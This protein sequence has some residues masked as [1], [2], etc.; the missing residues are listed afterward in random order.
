MTL[1]R[2]I[3]A[4][5][6]CLLAVSAQAQVSD[7]NDLRTLRVGMPAATLPADGFTDL[8]CSGGGKSLSNWQQ[9]KECRPDSTGLRVISFRYDDKP[10]HETVVAGQPV[11]LSLGI[12]DDGF[13]HAIT[14]R[15]DPSGRVFLRKRGVHFGERVMNHYGDDGW[16]CKDGE[17]AAGEEAVG[18][19]FIR[20]HCEKTFRDRSLVVDRALYRRTG[21][22]QDKFVSETVFTV[23]WIKPHA[24]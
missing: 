2:A 13:V 12:G 5:V 19:L 18:S 1:S 16:A 21:Q 22:S 9:W 20:Q 24:P 15:S 10:E 4:A 14:M 3:G 8:A 23:S 17:P 7:D 6:I 11:M